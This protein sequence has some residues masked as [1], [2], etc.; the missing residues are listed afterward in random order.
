M[1]TK[2]K[3]HLAIKITDPLTHCP[4]FTFLII[5]W[6]SHFRFLT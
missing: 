6:Y 1:L 4:L 3:E 2:Y 5:K